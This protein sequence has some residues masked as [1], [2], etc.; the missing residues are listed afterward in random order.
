MTANAFKED[1][2]HCIAAGMN[3]HL[4]KPLD[5]ELVKRTL[6]TCVA[7]ARAQSSEDSV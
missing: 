5:M 3:A 4:A 6:A 2:E 1:A 7:A